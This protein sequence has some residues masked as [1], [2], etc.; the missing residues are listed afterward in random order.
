[1]KKKGRRKNKERERKEEEREKWELQ[2][3]QESHRMIIM[4]PSFNKSQ[5]DAV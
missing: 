4:S 3:V 2:V 1:M 5:H